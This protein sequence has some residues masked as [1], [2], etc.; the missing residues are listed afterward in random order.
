MTTPALAFGPTL[1][2]AERTLTAVLHG[3]LAERHTTPATWYALRLIAM[4][5]LAR[6]D[7]LRLL[8]GS[9]STTAESAGEVVSR[10]EAD[11]LIR[12][13]SQVEL[14]AQGETAYRSLL[15]YVTGP[16]VELLSHFDA[17]DIDTTLRT[18]Q[19][20]TRRAEEELPAGRL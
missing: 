9:P 3:H 5:R 14:T 11:G 10:L 19:A 4:R 7:L 6:V 2:F 15:E 8:A 17:A 1:A 20:I 18:L 16:T 13:D 12:G